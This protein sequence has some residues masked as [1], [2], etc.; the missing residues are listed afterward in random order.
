MLLLLLHPAQSCVSIP[1][2]LHLLE[3]PGYSVFSIN[4]LSFH[5][6]VVIFAPSLPARIPCVYTGILVCCLF[7]RASIVPSVDLS[8]FLVSSLA[9][10]H[11]CSYFIC[12]PVSTVNLSRSGLH[13]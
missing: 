1:G 3:S 4:P 9:V 12:I 6:F 13:N 8:S 10:C 11:Q 5:Q 2:L 7:H